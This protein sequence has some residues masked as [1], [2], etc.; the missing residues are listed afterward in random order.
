MQSFSFKTQCTTAHTDNREVVNRDDRTHFQRRFTEVGVPYLTRTLE[1][2]DFAWVARRRTARV[3]VGSAVAAA[4]AT[5]V[6]EEEVMLNCIVERKTLSDLADSV[7]DG[8]FMEQKFR[9]GKCSIQHVIYLVEWVDVRD[10]ALRLGVDAITTAIISTQVH[11]G[12]TV[13]RVPSAEE[14]VH[15]L[16]S[17]TAY[18][19]D[20]VYKVCSLW[21]CAMT[22]AP[23]LMKTIKHTQQKPM[24]ILRP[25]CVEKATF[26][27]D[28][29]RL[30]DRMPEMEHIHLTFS[31]F[32]ALN[33]KTKLLTRR[34]QWAK[35]LMLI[36][37]M[38]AGKALTLVQT[39]PSRPQFLRAMLA[40]PDDASR[41]RVL[42][43]AGACG[44]GPAAGA[45]I[46]NG[47]RSIGAAL[48]RKVLA[49]HLN[50]AFADGAVV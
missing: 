10:S 7:R 3:P 38:S 26:A 24:Y 46:A 44:L 36:R 17:L 43:A 27:A 45:V 40:L 49:Q 48:A 19:R 42:T 34:D 16:A 21:F 1:L 37:G 14:T 20:V 5:R 28:M 29:M 4:A 39:W 35:E 2:G 47:K 31:G 12:F 9:L 50:V 32:N 25:E 8:R 18:L 41:V 13:K 33:T 23:K 22:C 11:S 15:Y 30:R 6:D